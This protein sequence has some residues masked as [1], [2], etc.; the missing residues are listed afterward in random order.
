[1]D[2]ANQQEAARLAFLALDTRKLPE[3]SQGTKRIGSVVVSSNE[4][5]DQLTI[6]END[7]DVTGDTIV[8]PI[9]FGA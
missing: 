2:A 9:D 5:V 3:V 7:S 1:L 4:I 8:Q 6:S